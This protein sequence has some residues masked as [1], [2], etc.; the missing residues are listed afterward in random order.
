M[1]RY[2]YG[3]SARRLALNKAAR[4]LGGELAV[5]IAQLIRIAGIVCLILAVST[6]ALGQN[7]NESARAGYCRESDKSAK[8]GVDSRQRRNPTSRP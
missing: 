6:T 3:A 8:P 2:P 4:K 5:T 1:K 7:S